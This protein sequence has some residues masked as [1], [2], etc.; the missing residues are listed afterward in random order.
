MLEPELM[1]YENFPN[2]VNILFNNTL[3]HVNESTYRLCEIE[4]Y[5]CGDGHRDEYTHCSEE[6]NQF[7]K[8]YFHKYQNGTYKSGTYKGLDI[9]LSPNKDTYFGVLIRSIKNMDNY[10]FIEG[11]CKTVDEILKQ[12]DRKPT[13]DGKTCSCTEV[14]HFTDGK[15]LPLDIYDVNNKL[16][17]EH[18][19]ET[20][21][22]DIL[23]G[24]RIGLSDKYP[25]F[26]DKPYRFVSS[27]YVKKQKNTL[28]PFTL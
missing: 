27:K 13:K 16:Y 5:Y 7:G 9:T 24:P 6:Q 1:T 28:V 8:F 14:K 20:D 22:Y 21:D 18:F 3:L 26:K 15:E 11:P 19:E 2:I 25:E 23:T 12:F 17:L 4:F 10:D